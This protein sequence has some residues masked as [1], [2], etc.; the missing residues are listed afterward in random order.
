MH[1]KEVATLDLFN[2]DMIYASKKFLLEVTCILH[3]NKMKETYNKYILEYQNT[4]HTGH[5]CHFKLYPFL[6]RTLSYIW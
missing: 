6:L 2:N 4:W 1:S 5:L 3:V